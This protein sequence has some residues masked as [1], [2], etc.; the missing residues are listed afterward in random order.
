MKDFQ[1]YRQKKNNEFAQQKQQRLELRKGKARNVNR[2]EPT[3][4]ANFLNKERPLNISMK[5]L[6][7]TA[8]SDPL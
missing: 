2:P 7:E 6:Y 1:G 4:S 5:N 8:K 3:S